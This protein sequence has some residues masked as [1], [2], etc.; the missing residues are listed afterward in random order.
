MLNLDEKGITLDEVTA[1]YPKRFQTLGY[2]MLL[3]VDAY[4]KPRIASSFELGVNV[5]LTLLFM[6]PGQF[7]SIPDLGIDIGQYLYDYSDN[8]KLPGIIKNQINDQCNRLQYT[9][10]DIDCFFDRTP[11]GHNALVVK[12]TGTE[13]M[14]RG[15]M[16]NVVYIGI[17]YDKLNRLYAKRYYDTTTR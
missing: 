10:M 4:N 11:D 15:T 1:K 12:I 14:A 13:T 6:K 8:E 5:V 9:F 2:D 17:S 3:D 7:P 16:G